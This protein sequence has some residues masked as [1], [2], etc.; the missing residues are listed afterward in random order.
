[1]RFRPPQSGANS[2]KRLSAGWLLLLD[3]LVPALGP[4]P[5]ATARMVHDRKAA[6]AGSIPGRAP[7]H[8]HGAPA[9]P[10]APV[11]RLGLGSLVGVWTVRIGVWVF[12]VYFLGPPEL[13]IS[14]VLL[15]AADVGLVVFQIRQ[16]IIRLSVLDDTRDFVR[17]QL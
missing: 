11:R 13:L 3:L 1:M 17:R 15:G 5:G 12:G 6:G 16:D 8:P 9:T 4:P 7:Q 10:T 14:L 2:A